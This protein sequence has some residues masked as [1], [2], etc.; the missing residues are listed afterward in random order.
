M[1][2][3]RCS[4]ETDRLLPHGAGKVL[5]C[6]KCSNKWAKIWFEMY[7]RDHSFMWKVKFDK[8]M[9]GNKSREVVVFN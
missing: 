2:C 1:I 8:F 5:L 4:K 3:D 6:E 7:E 9:Q